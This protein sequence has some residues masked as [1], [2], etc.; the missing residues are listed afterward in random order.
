MHGVTDLPDFPRM[1]SHG[2]FT[3]TSNGYFSAWASFL[4]ATRYAYESSAHVRKAMDQGA[5]AMTSRE[6]TDTWNQGAGAAASAEPAAGAT[7]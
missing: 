2:P 4:F 3:S 6:G 1:R 7:A 5:A